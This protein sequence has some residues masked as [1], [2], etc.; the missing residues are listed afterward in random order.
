MTSILNVASRALLLQT[1]MGPV[2]TQEGACPR[3]KFPSVWSAVG[4]RMRKSAKIQ[5]EKAVRFVH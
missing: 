4:A 3:H 1:R 2:R 5:S